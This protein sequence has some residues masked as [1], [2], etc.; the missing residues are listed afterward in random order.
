MV[1]FNPV[2]LRLALLFSLLLFSSNIFAVPQYEIFDIDSLL[3]VDG[4]LINLGSHATVVN[5]QGHVAGYY[6]ARISGT[7]R[8]KDIPFIYRPGTGVEQL[9]PTHNRN[10]HI[11]DLNNKDQF[12]GK[13]VY[14]GSVEVDFIHRDGWENLEAPLESVNKINDSGDIVGIM[15]KKRK[16]LTNSLAIW[17]ED[18]TVVDLLE[19]VRDCDESIAGD[20]DGV[21]RMDFDGLIQIYPA[22]M[23]MNNQGQIVFVAM[24]TRSTGRNIYTYNPGV[25]VKKIAFVY[26]HETRLDGV[27]INNSGMISVSKNRFRQHRHAVDLYSIDGVLQS[28]GTVFGSPNDWGEFTV[29]NDSN[30]LLGSQKTAFSLTDVSQVVDNSAFLPNPYSHFDSK[31]INNNNV[32]VGD[33]FNDSTNTKALAFLPRAGVGGITIDGLFNDWSGHTAYSDAPDD[34]LLVNWDQV[35]TDERGESLS[36]SYT[37]IGDIDKA[38]LFLWNIYLD[39]DKQTGTGY[40]FSLLGADYLLQGKSLYQ[41]T[42]TGKD[43]SWKYIKEVNY[44]VSGVRAELSV[45]KSALGLANDANSYHALFYGTTADGGNIDYLLVDVNGGAGSVVMEEVIAPAP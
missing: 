43:W 9:S 11:T 17:K 12:I 19:G 20:C 39:T 23:D 13:W 33:G 14:G 37:N 4:S 21:N 40:G 15:T 1:L 44:T 34:G 6:T 32:I 7:S 45:A 27:S 2:R 22:H 38:Q 3:G 16:R 26:E 25:G 41:Y 42:G 29:I 10:T 24:T 5:D 35:W 36:F 18:Y 8:E 31:D 30:V 28:A